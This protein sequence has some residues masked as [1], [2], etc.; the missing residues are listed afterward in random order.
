MFNKSTTKTEENV[1]K[2]FK[3]LANYVVPCKRARTNC[4]WIRS[5]HEN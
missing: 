2:D 3:K 4:K 1:K 5:E